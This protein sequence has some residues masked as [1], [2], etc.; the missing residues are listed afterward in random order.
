MYKKSLQ[1]LAGFR[2]HTLYLLS[3]ILPFFHST[4]GTPKTG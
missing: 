2:P 4:T 1:V 3:S